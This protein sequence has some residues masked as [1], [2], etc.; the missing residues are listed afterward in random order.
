MRTVS[1]D[2]RLRMEGYLAH[3][4]DLN[5]SLDGGHPYRSSAPTFNQPLTQISFGNKPMGSFTHNLTG[6]T[7]STTYKYRFLGGGFWALI[8]RNRNFQN[9]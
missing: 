7:A 1:S 6:L 8:L 2:D 5:G 4:W 9:H 3:K